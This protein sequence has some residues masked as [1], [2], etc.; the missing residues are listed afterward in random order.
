MHLT[1]D[2]GTVLL[3][4]PPATLRDLPGVLWDPRVS[5]FRAPAWRHPEIRRAIGE[6]PFFDD[7]RPDLPAPRLPESCDLRPYQE[8][9]LSAWNLAGQRGQLILP[10][11]AGKTRVAVAALLTARRRAL[12]LVPTRV[13]LHQWV[14]VLGEAGV[15]PVGQIGDGFH[16]E[17]PITIA[18]FA[19]ATRRA[20][21]LGN[22][23]DLLVVDEAHHFG[24]PEGD[25]AL[26]MSIAAARLG[27][28]AT[29]VEDPTRRS[30]LQTLLGPEV[31]RIGVEALSGSWLAPLDLITLTL[32]L[33]VEE[34]AA[35]N[36]DVACFQPVCR[37][38]FEQCPGASWM[39][40]VRSVGRTEPGRQALAAWRRSRAGVRLTAAKR[41]M[42]ASLLDRHRASRTL[43]FTPD[44]ET[45][46]EIARSLLVPFITADIAKKERGELLTRFARGDLRVLV[47]PRV[48]DEGMDVPAAEVALLVGGRHGVRQYIQR[49][50]RVL[51]PAEGKRALVYELVTRD[52]FEA[53]HARTNRRALG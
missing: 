20:E 15:Q 50:G 46:C 47:S 26:E 9:A 33:T 10:T 22:R 29:P 16:D 14:K 5:A 49:I 36:A 40:F 39:D 21:V 53:N 38:F 3:S 34:R 31:Y 52:T 51:R 23:F 13:L 37:R 2:R 11:G 41:A 32:D 42:I 27:L 17:Q 12:C 4:G 8:A 30:R 19:S 24:C 28:T 35:Y 7:V 18:T 43:V 1:W 6:K 48:L 45:A 44:Q 25:E